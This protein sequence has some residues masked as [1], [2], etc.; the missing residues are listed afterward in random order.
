MKAATDSCVFG[1]AAGRRVMKRHRPV[2]A[3]LQ[4]NARSCVQGDPKDV[5]VALPRGPMQRRQD[6][7]GKLRSRS[8]L[9]KSLKN[10]GI[11]VALAGLTGALKARTD[12]EREASH[13]RMGQA[14]RLQGPR[15]MPHPRHG[16]PRGRQRRGA[17]DHRGGAEASSLAEDTGDESWQVPETERKLLFTA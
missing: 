11:A 7:P 1:A 15:E 16:R 5:D 12:L 6:R 8:R 14:S 2:I 17:A 9:H 4:V 13:P 10:A 3:S